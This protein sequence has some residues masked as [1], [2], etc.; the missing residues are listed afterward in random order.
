MLL[1]KQTQ[2]AS[3]EQKNGMKHMMAH[4]WLS[5]ADA[6]LKSKAQTRQLQFDADNR[7][8]QEAQQKIQDTTQKDL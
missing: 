7:M 5:D 4:Q 2:E 1:M 8:L 3:D 6:H